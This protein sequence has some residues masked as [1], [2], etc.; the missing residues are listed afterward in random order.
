[1]SVLS[2]RDPPIRTKSRRFFCRCTTRSYGRA[3]AVE[4]SYE[5]LFVDERVE[6]SHFERLATWWRRM[7]P[8][9]DS[10]GAGREVTGSGAVQTSRGRRSVQRRSAASG[11]QASSM[12]ATCNTRREDMPRCSKRSIRG[13][14]I[15]SGWRS[16]AWT[17][18]Y[19]QDSSAYANWR[20][21]EGERH[22]ASRFRHHFPAIAREVLKESELYANCTA[23]SRR[24][25]ALYGARV[26]EGGRSPVPR[27]AGIR[28]MA[29]GRT[30]AG[31][32]RHSDGKF[33]VEVRV[34]AGRPDAFFRHGAGHDLDRPGRPDPGP[35]PFRGARRIRWA[36]RS[37]GGGVNRA[38]GPLIWPR[39]A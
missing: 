26:V 38:W 39:H 31:D 16:A 29:S 32:V 18:R 2:N 5:I 25:P 7:A 11:H 20:I 21:G 27:S 36:M 14:D 30:F 4:A 3:G 22:R 10:P 37:G 17:T 15:A 19:A 33:M 28:T 9:G 8:Q 23:S 1:M 35:E 6:R 24:W 34:R 13:N 12:D